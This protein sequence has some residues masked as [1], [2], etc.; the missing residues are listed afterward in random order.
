M[1][2]AL[3]TS[4]RYIQFRTDRTTS[5]TRAPWCW[6]KS[7]ITG[8]VM[9]VPVRGCHGPCFR[10][11]ALVTEHGPRHPLPHP[12]R[13]PS[14]ANSVFNWCARG[15]GGFV[16]SSTA[17]PSVLFFRM[18]TDHFHFK[19]VVWNYMVSDEITSRRRPPL[20]TGIKEATVTCKQCGH[21]WR[22]KQQNGDITNK[23]GGP[24]ILC[25]QCEFEEVVQGGLPE[26]RPTAPSASG[27]QRSAP[28]SPPNT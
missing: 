26:E 22:A 10:N 18:E 27:P 24:I 15:G 1:L 16:T 11:L 7:N 23:P 28:S 21:V 14:L 5:R 20:K 8:L 6:R 13:Q 4:S 12:S 2:P 19:D 17:V 3:H 9:I 25:P